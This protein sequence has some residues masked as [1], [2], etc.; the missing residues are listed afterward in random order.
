M[1][2]D[3]DY[4]PTMNHEFFESG[5]SDLQHDTPNS[6]LPLAMTTQQLFLTV[7]GPKTGLSLCDAGPSF[8]GGR[9]FDLEREGSGADVPPPLPSYQF[10]NNTSP[11]SNS[12]PAAGRPSSSSSHGLVNMGPTAAV[13]R[14]QKQRR[15][16]PK[17]MNLASE[18]I[19]IIGRKNASMQAA[20]RSGRRGPLSKKRKDKINRMR[21]KK[22][23]A[24]CFASHVEVSCHRCD[25]RTIGL[26][27]IQVL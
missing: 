8:Q 14:P 1:P 18:T 22:A 7:P 15:I 17:S 2:S 11:V 3:D 27:V 26:T 10:S 21:E 9:E 5:M 6:V 25:C 13:E 16:M 12:S 24:A 4:G 23:C 20:K 19:G